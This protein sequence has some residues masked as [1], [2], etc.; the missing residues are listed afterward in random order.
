MSNLRS[1]HWTESTSCILLQ[2]GGAE[3]LI[4]S[5]YQDMPDVTAAKYT[6]K[7][8]VPLWLFSCIKAQSSSCLSWTRLAHE[9][10]N[11][12][13]SSHVVEFTIDEKEPKI[14]TRSWELVD[15]SC[16]LSHFNFLFWIF[17][18]DKGLL[19]VVG[20]TCV[21]KDFCFNQRFHVAKY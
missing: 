3:V 13:L 11:F 7:Q 12:L 4:K 19:V 6:I 1:A 8:L 2:G 15:K 10:Y 9:K 17:W 18:E 5:P 20:E 16:N 14:R 21:R